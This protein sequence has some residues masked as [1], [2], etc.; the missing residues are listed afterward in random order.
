MSEN[1][2]KIFRKLTSMGIKNIT[3]FT[4]QGEPIK[5]TMDPEKTKRVV[6]LALGI[7][8]QARRIL[9]SL[10]GSSAQLKTLKATTENG[11]LHLIIGKG[12]ILAYLAPKML[13][14]EQEKFFEIANKIDALFK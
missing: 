3:F 13:S 1:V 4:H 2:E 6:N 11:T 14:E 10:S 8:E 9:I 7:L 5:T 12:H